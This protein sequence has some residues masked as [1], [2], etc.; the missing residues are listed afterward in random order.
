MTGSGASGAA[1]YVLEVGLR[2]PP[3]VRWVEVDD[4]VVVHDASTGGF[5]DLNESAGELWLIMSRSRWSEHAALEHLIGVRSMSPAEARAI[6][7]SFVAELLHR[8]ALT[9][10]DP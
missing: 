8:G 5:I 10:D 4:G 2:P 3:G 7:R 6:T 9:S 1:G